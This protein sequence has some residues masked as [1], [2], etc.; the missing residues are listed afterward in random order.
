[1]KYCTKCGNL[2]KED[3][4]FCNKCGNPTKIVLKEREEIKKVKNEENKEK[5]L[6][7][8][9]TLLIIIASVVFAVINWDEMTN[10]FK[11]LFLLME[12]LVFLSLSMFS[13]KLNYMMPHKFLWFIGIIFIPVILNLLAQYNM[14]GDFSKGNNL[15]V[16]LALSSV[17]CFVI[18][19]LSYKFI[20]SNIFLY[21]GYTFVYSFI[22]LSKHLIPSI[23]EVVIPPE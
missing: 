16:Y 10:I 13:K 9:G 23:Q 12:S 18:Y 1:M 3:S 17:F 8:L 19:V 6:L 15:Y 7:L 4:R 20:K 2:L 11:V 14:I 21:F 5:L 22:I